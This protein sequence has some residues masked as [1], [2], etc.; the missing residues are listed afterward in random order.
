MRN[1]ARL[2]EAVLLKELLRPE[3]HWQNCT[4]GLVGGRAQRNTICVL[5]TTV[6]RDVRTASKAD[7]T[8]AVAGLE[9]WPFKGGWPGLLCT[10]LPAG[11]SRG[12]LFSLDS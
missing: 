1:E 3:V 8:A 7:H 2:S 6:N 12:M 5:V 10:S 11:F 9:A 4:P